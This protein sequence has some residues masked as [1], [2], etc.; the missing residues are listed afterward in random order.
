MRDD[1]LW[2]G[3]TAICK[4][5]QS[6]RKLSVKLVGKRI[7]EQKDLY[8]FLSNAVMYQLLCCIYK[9]DKSDKLVNSETQNTNF[10]YTFELNV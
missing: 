6:F 4:P 10:L 8:N 2:A 7:F 3:D 1:G 5:E 9:M